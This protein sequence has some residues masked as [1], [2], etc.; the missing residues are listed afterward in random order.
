[1]KENP[2]PVLIG[3]LPRLELIILQLAGVLTNEFGLVL[4][5]FRNR[6]AAVAGAKRAGEAVGTPRG[7]N[8]VLPRAERFPMQT[9][10]RYRDIF[11]KKWLEGKT[12]NVSGTGVLFRGKNL[13]APRTRVEMIFALPTKGSGACGASIQCF[14]QIVRRAPPVIAGDAN[15]LAATI[16]EYR[17]MRGG[18]TSGE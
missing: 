18:G 13:L 7:A 14:G 5:K 4:K 2:A 16:E 3:G 10:I 9:P 6:V 1:M 17:L 15:G 8:P 12:E 11:K